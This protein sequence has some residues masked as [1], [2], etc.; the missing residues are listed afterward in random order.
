MSDRKTSMTPI[1]VGGV[2]ALLGILIGL[3]FAVNAKERMEAAAAASAPADGMVDTPVDEPQAIDSAQLPDLPAV[4]PTTA[5]AVE[6]DTVADEPTTA[7]E[8]ATANEPV[9]DTPT[10]T[11]SPEHPE[12]HTV[13][14]E[15][16]PPS[17]PDDFE[18]VSPE[19]I[20]RAVQQ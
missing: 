14:T 16:Q 15:Q 11:E 1:I 12:V 19:E 9:P 18:E 5:V 3:Y 13:A 10:V 4:D 7:D 2:I 8:P 20:E 6:D 17:P